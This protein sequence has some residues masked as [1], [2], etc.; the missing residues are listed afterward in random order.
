MIISSMEN[1]PSSIAVAAILNKTNGI[2]LKVVG[3]FVGCHASFDSLMDVL[4]EQR[5][6]EIFFPRTSA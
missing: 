2:A 6:P 5:R 1:I 3:A 4:P